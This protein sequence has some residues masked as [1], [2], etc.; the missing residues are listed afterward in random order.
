MKSLKIVA[1]LFV[2][3]AFGSQAK[4]DIIAYDV[5]SGLVGNQS[6]FG[7]TLGMDFD[8]ASGGIKVTQ[9][10]IFD[11]GG[12]GLSAAH[13]VS[14]YN[15]DTQALVL[16][17]AI[18]SGTV[19]PLVNGS[20]FVAVPAFTLV[21]GHY[22]VATFGFSAADPNYNANRNGNTSPSVLNTGGGLIS[23]TGTGRFGPAGTYPGTAD[24]GEVLVNPYG[25]ATFQ[26]TAVPEPGSIVLLGLGS[27]GLVVLGLRRRKTSAA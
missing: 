4:A 6:E 11:S 1:A 16:A 21:S 23:F 8:V 2:L 19:A 24:A 22:T 26:Y 12:D 25:A 13:T 14:I 7:G 15:R 17:T 3:A 5:T 9:L 10:G 18:P 27:A 20:R